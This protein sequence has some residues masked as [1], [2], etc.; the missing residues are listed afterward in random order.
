[1]PPELAS[2]FQRVIPDGQLFR[3]VE[4]GECGS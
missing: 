1:M 4:V 3:R 2:L